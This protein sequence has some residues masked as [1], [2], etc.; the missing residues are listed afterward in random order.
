MTFFSEPSSEGDARVREQ[1]EAFARAHEANRRRSEEGTRRARVGLIFLSIGMLLLVALGFSP[2]PY[3][4]RSPGPVFDALGTVQASQDDPT[5]VEV[6]TIGGADTF[7][8]SEGQLDVMTV[9]VGGR[10]ENL[11]NWFEVFLALIT[12]S[13]DVLPVEAYYADAETGEQRDAQNAALMQGSEADA[14]AAALLNEGYDVGTALAIVSV[15]DDGAAAGMLEP[16]D[17]VTSVSGIPVESTDGL[18]AAVAE[19]SGGDLGNLQAVD[20]VVDRSGETKTFSITPRAGVV[21]GEERALLGVTVATQHDFPIDV[22]IEL[23]NV[24]GPSAGLIFALAVSDKL[25]DGDLT[26]GLHVAG[27]GTMSPDGTVGSIGGITQ[28]LYAAVDVGADLFLAPAD[29]CQDVLDGGIPGDIP[30]YA[31][32]TLDEAEQVIQTV[33]DGGDT[34]ALR[35][36]ESVLGS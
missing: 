13:N 5:Q 33:G 16:G 14:I 24:G 23:G 27:T 21:E 17:I 4:V 7:E 8:P 34:A 2:A 31:V 30:V 10:P 26:R 3:V 22:S 19:V 28:K 35:T 11:P 36:C 25:A 29:N 6:I 18:P 15:G 20:V 12:P 9:N 1:S 32:S